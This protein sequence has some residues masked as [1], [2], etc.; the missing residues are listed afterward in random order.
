MPFNLV[1]TLLAFDLFSD[2]VLVFQRL[3]SYLSILE[4]DIGFFQAN[5]DKQLNHMAL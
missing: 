3:Q 5:H 2:M 1:H 4:K